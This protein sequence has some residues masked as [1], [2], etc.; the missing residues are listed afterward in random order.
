[1]NAVP[2]R[3]GQLAVLAVSML[4]VAMIFGA[5]FAGA[6]Y[7]VPLGAAVVLATVVAAAASVRI[8]RVDAVLLVGLGCWAVFA[9][10]ALFPSRWGNGFPG[11][12][13]H[14]FSRGLTDGWARMLTVG[15]P[16]GPTGEL[17]I[18]PALLL[19]VATVAAVVLTL[20]TDAV[21]APLLPPLGAVVIGL[22][23]VA[24]RGRAQLW[25]AGG[26][27]LAGL[28]LALLRASSPAG[29]ARGRTG[30]WAGQAGRRFPN[31]LSGRLAFGI[32]VVVA[33]AAAGIAGAAVLPVA[34]G[35][36]RFDPRDH[37][38]PPVEVTP[39]LNPLMDVK[40]QLQADPPRTLLTVHL[41]SAT[42]RVAVSRIRTAALADFDGASWTDAGM[43]VATGQT[44][45]DSPDPE[46]LPGAVVDAEVTV[47]RL[48]GVYLP[49]LGRPLSIT[50]TSVA[51]ASDSGVLATT[52]PLR[53][54]LRYQLRA[55][56]PPDLA[57]ASA[58]EQA[59]VKPASGKSVHRYLE[60]PEALPPGLAGIAG[61]LTEKATTSYGKL[62]EIEKFL[63]DGERFPYD[64]SARPGHS[65]AAVWRMVRP[66]AKEF[67]RS[68]A[69]QHAAAFA[70]FARL[71]GFPSRVAV[72][73]LVD[74]RSRAGPG[75]YRVTTRYAH[76]WPE[77][78]LAGLGWVAFEPTDTSQLWRKLSPAGSSPG[79][80]GTGTLPPVVEP[81][82]AIVEPP[83]LDPEREKGGEG[84]RAGRAARWFGLLP[85]IT[86]AAIFLFFLLTAGE[87]ARRRWCR[88]HTGTPAARI[89]GAWREVR[90]RLAER[91][92]PRS[93]ALTIQ[94]V[95]GRT[96]DL[97]GMGRVPA[98]VGE[99]ASIVDTAF[100]AATEP[101]EA[102]AGRA[103][104]LTRLVRRE[105]NQTGGLPTRARVIFDPR[106]LMPGGVRGV[107]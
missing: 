107:Q 103:W 57:G 82:A 87:K 37:R 60:L 77:I 11:S 91:G 94:D 90:D 93:R 44:L 97:R 16:V 28:L 27:L 8:R 5:F 88:H 92:L 47:D 81:A 32:P 78:N 52:T 1:M 46:P 7:L 73:Y 74:E 13:F 23:L 86:I 34:D 40:N 45:P 12:V 19:W 83:L 48:G 51:F 14:A 42:E 80:S 69:E 76:A 29:P 15:L 2:W 79:G 3:G 105:L 49:S 64:L 31:T 71:A 61:G 55:V 75:T 56:V 9:L 18:I 50:G 95:V 33:L 98:Q 72:G 85:A 58:A 70:L 104:E 30:G 17:L 66:G 25:L 65:S 106:S 6:G 10:L 38:H 62:V 67:R 26:I 36:D 99:L 59:A 89:G 63:R 100:F 21:L 4:G 39:A 20:R 22:L 68:Y 102:D 43:F 35:S 96:G 24:H 53:P 101:G 41:V 84:G 54:G